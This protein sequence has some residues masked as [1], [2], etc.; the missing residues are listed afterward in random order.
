MR[1]RHT[2]VLLS[3]RPVRGDFERACQG[4]ADCLGLWGLDDLDQALASGPEVAVIDGRDDLGA[5]LIEARLA[6]DRGVLVAVLGPPESSVLLSALRAGARDLLD[7]ERPGQ[8]IDFIHRNIDR[9]SGRLLAG[10]GAHGGCGVTTVCTA[11]AHQLAADGQG[12]VVLVDLDEA[13]RGLMAALDL[14]PGYTARDLVDAAARLIPSRLHEL[15]IRTP[16]GFWALPQHEDVFEQRDI[17]PE[18][19]PALL[20]AL[21]QGFDHVVVDLGNG[22]SELAQRVAFDAEAVLVVSTQELPALRTANLRIQQLQ[23]LGLDDLHVVIN[24]YQRRAEPSLDQIRA[25]LRVEELLTVAEDSSTAHRAQVEARPATQVAP[26]SPLGFDL[27]DLER[28]LVG[29]TPRRRRSGW[30]LF[31]QA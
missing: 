8:L 12:R 2:Y 4:Q 3:E 31:G 20:S 27:G 17:E 21:R 15:L 5:A 10:L 22:F 11:L 19:L 1:T 14:D 16:W 30:W 28:R 6:A 13:D 18:E 25:R 29:K 26:G 7:P 23:R 9:R 24:R